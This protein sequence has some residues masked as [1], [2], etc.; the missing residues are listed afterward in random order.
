MDENQNIYAAPADQVPEADV[1]RLK[2]HEAMLG[3]AAL[4]TDPDS[5]ERGLEDEINR[6][7]WGIEATK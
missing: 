5:L 1:E 6:R 4:S 2:R 7:A 3:L